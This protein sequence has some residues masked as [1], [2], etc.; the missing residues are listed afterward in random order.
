VSLRRLLFQ[1]APERAAT[2]SELQQILHTLAELERLL[3]AGEKIPDR[4]RL[5]PPVTL[6]RTTAHRVKKTAELYWEKG[7]SGISYWL[8]ALLRLVASHPGEELLP[9][10]ERVTPLR[11]IPRKQDASAEERA[12]LAMRMLTTMI[13]QGSLAAQATWLKILPQ[14]RP[15]DR[16]VLLRETLARL[17]A[18]QAAPFLALARTMATE[19]PALET[20][21]ILRRLLVTCGE[22]YPPDP[23]DGEI[24]FELKSYKFACLLGLRSTDTLFTL[25]EAIQRA[26]DW[27]NDHLWCFFL[28]TQTEGPLRWPAE[29]VHGCEDLVLTDSDA[30]PRAARPGEFAPEQLGSLGLR[31][32]DKLLYNFDFG[33]NHVFEL[34]A[35]AIRAQRP[36]EARYPTLTIKKGK[37]PRQY[38]FEPDD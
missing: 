9:F 4:L 30:K 13:G 19:A 22:S 1:I 10:W 21:Y 5:P 20:R 16:G 7:G 37:P 31:V 34:R 14:L 18:L 3:H 17:S 25:H 24:E 12:W 11:K 32:G 28:G 15:L 35:A 27:D 2:T 36:S 26:L 29:D 33:D 8:P 6:D 23:L 38:G